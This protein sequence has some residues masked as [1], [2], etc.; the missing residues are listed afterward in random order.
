MGEGVTD[1]EEEDEE[2]AVTPHMARAPKGSPESTPEPQVGL[3]PAELKASSLTDLSL[4]L[5]LLQGR[6]IVMERMPLIP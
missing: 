3:T 4:S 1:S 5:I 2:R 6:R